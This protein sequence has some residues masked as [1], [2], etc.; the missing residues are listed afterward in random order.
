MVGQYGT[1]GRTGFNTYKGIK[2]AVI[3][4][5]HEWNWENSPIRIGIE[6]E[7]EETSRLTKEKVTIRKEDDLVYVQENCLRSR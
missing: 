2:N 1:T 6:T 5:C 4:T 3:E 7:W